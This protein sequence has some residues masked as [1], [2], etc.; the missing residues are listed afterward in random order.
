M[1]WRNFSSVLSNYSKLVQ[2]LTL[3]RNNSN[4]RISISNQRSNKTSKILF[5]SWIKELRKYNLVSCSCERN[6]NTLNDLNKS[7]SNAVLLNID[8][9]EYMHCKNNVRVVY[10][11]QRISVIIIVGNHLR[12]KYFAGH[13][14]W[15][16]FNWTYSQKCLNWTKFYCIEYVM[17]VN[18][19]CEIN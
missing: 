17:A 4:N 18:Q 10:M 12:W 3:A 16:V 15:Q 13:G 19:V 9:E 14:A 11:L 7:K 5:D 6:I 2:L 8:N 1:K